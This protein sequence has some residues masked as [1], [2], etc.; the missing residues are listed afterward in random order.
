[1]AVRRSPGALVLALYPTAGTPSCLQ[2]LPHHHLPNPGFEGSLAAELPA[3]TDRGNERVVHCVPARLSVAGDRSR[4]THKRIKPQVVQRL[5]RRDLE[6]L[7]H[8]HTI[9]EVSRRV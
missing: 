5:E 3:T 7:A 6:I 2:R 9:R 1:M 8:T 4:C